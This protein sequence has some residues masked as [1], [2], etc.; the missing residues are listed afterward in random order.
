MF[1]SVSVL[2]RGA[3]QASTL[4]ITRGMGTNGD[5]SPWFGDEDAIGTSTGSIGES[6]Y[7]SSTARNCIPSIPPPEI[8]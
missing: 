3:A 6:R 5:S 1:T 7:Y 4:I 2:M 8:F